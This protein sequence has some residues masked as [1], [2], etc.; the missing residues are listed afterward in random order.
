MEVLQLG[1]ACLRQRGSRGP[2]R[3]LRGTMCQYVVPVE[4]GSRRKGKGEEAYLH[5]E[6]WLEYVNYRLWG[7]FF[8]CKKR[9][10]LTTRI[11]TAE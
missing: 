5:P 4:S 3:Y 2:P 9:Q 7:V 6:G 8:V 10:D 11:E 1:S